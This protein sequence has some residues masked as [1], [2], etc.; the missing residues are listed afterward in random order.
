MFSIKKI[1]AVFIL[2]Y[3]FTLFAFSF[4]FAA[5]GQ[6]VPCG[7]PG[8]HSCTICDFFEM[9]KR[10]TN[11]IMFGIIPVTAAFFLLL[12]G[13]YLVWTKGDPTAL[14]NA[15]NIIKVVVIGFLVVFIGWVFVNTMFM[16][17]GIADWDGFKLNDSWWKISAKCSMSK[18]TSENC[19]DGIW[20]DDEGCDPKMTVATCQ[21]KAGYSKK[22]CNE[23]ISKCNP[24]TCKAEYCGDG[25]VNGDEACDYNESLE[26]CKKR[27]PDLSEKKCQALIDSCTTDC[28]IVAEAA[29]SAADKSKIGKG[30]WLTNDITDREKYCQRGKYICDDD[31]ESS[32]YNKVVCR[33]LDPKVYDECC[34]NQGENLDQL[35][36]DIVRI[37]DYVTLGASTG[38]FETSSQ[39]I[40]CMSKSIDCDTVCKSKGK[41]CVGVGLSLWQKN[42]CISVIHHNYNNCNLSENLATNDCRAKYCLTN[43]ICCEGGDA[44]DDS[45]KPCCKGTM[46]DPYYGRFTGSGPQFSVGETACYCGK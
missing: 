43:A 25:E 44:C 39:M 42:K 12:G 21:A 20:Q 16:A 22:L 15:K 2:I 32:T 5:D 18:Q 4:V 1:S 24:D 10:V 34:L 40:A 23:I 29:C 41:V 37:R 28:K 45:L 9:S 19:G 38:V 14:I 26:S 35:D 7:G 36:F 17:L 3:L 30:C 6:L 31:P 11:Y 33:A 13:G 46:T 8:Q 27:K